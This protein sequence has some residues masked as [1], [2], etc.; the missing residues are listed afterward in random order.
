MELDE[1]LPILDKDG[2]VVGYH[3][4]KP[5][6]SALQF[7]VEKLEKR[8][9]KLEGTPYDPEGDGGEVVV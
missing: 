6:K 5:S 8:I 4:F 3:D 2:L 1:R 7:K 9:V